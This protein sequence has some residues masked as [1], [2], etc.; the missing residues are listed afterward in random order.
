[1][2]KKLGV[3][4][5]LLTCP[6]HA[7]LVLLLLGSTTAGVWLSANMGLTFGLFTAAFMLFLWLATRPERTAVVDGLA[8]EPCAPV[9]AESAQGARPSTGHEPTAG[10]PSGGPVEPILTESALRDRRRIASR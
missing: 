2:L 3:V 1:M 6:C 7:G 9:E 4:G 8:C 5:A 10:A